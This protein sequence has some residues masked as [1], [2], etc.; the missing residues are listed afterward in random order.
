MATLEK[1][2]ERKNT[3]LFFAV[4]V[5]GDILFLAKQMHDHGRLDWN[6][7]M[8]AVGALFFVVVFHRYLNR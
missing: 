1:S 4:V 7:W 6:D 8:S 3:I 2:S 5:F